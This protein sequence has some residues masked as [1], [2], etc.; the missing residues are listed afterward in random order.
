MKQAFCIWTS[1][2]LQANIR[3]CAAVRVQLQLC[4]HQPAVRTCPHCSFEN[5]TVAGTR[6]GG[7]RRAKFRDLRRRCS[8]DTA[9]AVP[10]AFPAGLKLE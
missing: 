10:T 6:V 7:R 9:S 2:D 3:A 8:S 1:I 4:V 5:F